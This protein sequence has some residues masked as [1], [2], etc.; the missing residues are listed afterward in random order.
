MSTHSTTVKTRSLSTRE[1]S[2]PPDLFTHLLTRTPSVSAQRQVES[3][4]AC[5]LG[6]DLQRY[7]P[8]LLQQ[9][10]STNLS[11][12]ETRQ[13]LRKIYDNWRIRSTLESRVANESVSKSATC[14]SPTASRFLGSPF[15]HG[16]SLSFT[17]AAGRWNDSSD[18]SDGIFESKG[19]SSTFS[20]NAVKPRVRIAIGVT[21]DHISNDPFHN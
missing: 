10:S 12:R 4:A 8:D 17:S 3:L 6:S 1:R 5:R 15:R 21:D 13:T 11:S 19:L 9:P 18:G 2:W 7:R 16:P 14:F 20:P